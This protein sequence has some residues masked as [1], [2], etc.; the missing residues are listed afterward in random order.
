[1]SKLGT[2]E[3]RGAIATACIL[4]GVP[5]ADCECGGVGTRLTD[6]VHAEWC[7][8]RLA[9]VFALEAQQARLGVTQ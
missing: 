9:P 1:M 2:M 6:I 4:D 7:A 3:F 5:Y 8:M